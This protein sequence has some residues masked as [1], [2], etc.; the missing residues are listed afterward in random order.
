MDRD[1]RTVIYQV[2]GPCIALAVFLL[3]CLTIDELGARMESI[4]VCVLGYIMIFGWLRSNLPPLGLV[5]T[6]EYVVLFFLLT[7]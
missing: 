7:S 4:G 3:K 5:T 6:G 2:F 1:P